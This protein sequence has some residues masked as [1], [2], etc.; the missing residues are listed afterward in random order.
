MRVVFIDRFHDKGALK[1]H[2]RSAARVHDLDVSNDETGGEIAD[3][4]IV[5][6]FRNAG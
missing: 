6:G 4:E 5:I 3:A 2:A 1:G